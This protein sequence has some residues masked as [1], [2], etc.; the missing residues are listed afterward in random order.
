MSQVSFIYHQVVQ[1]SPSFLFTKCI[2]FI[3]FF[4]FYNIFSY[5]Y[6]VQIVHILDIRHKIAPL[7]RA[8][9]VNM[10]ICS[11]SCVKEREREKYR[12]IYL[13]GPTSTLHCSLNL[14]VHILEKFSS[15]GKPL[16]FLRRFCSC[17]LV[18]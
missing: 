9:L 13:D 15:V 16:G 11:K 1:F 7:L 18:G 17:L 10:Q 4:F 6:F 5:D 3:L 12:L 14:I 8:L 2:N